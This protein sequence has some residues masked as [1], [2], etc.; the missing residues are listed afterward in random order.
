MNV[1]GI[2]VQC[3]VCF[4]FV[5]NMPRGVWGSVDMIKVGPQT[6]PVETYLT[7]HTLTC[8]APLAQPQPGMSIRVP[9]DM[10]LDGVSIRMPVP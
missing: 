5:T 10:V 1:E 6:G 4:A 7:P 8:D 9:A 2:F 3:R